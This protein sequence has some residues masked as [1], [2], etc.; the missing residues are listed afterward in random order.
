MEIS[1]L[2]DH[3]LGDYFFLFQLV[4][5]ILWILTFSFFPRLG[6]SK[7]ISLFYRITPFIF[8]PATLVFAEIRE[9]LYFQRVLESRNNDLVY[10]NLTLWRF[11]GI[12]S[13]GLSG[14][15]LGL[16]AFRRNTGANKPA[17]DKPDPAAS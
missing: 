4:W 16:F 8:L 10:D 2:T 14:L 3:L 1:L 13:Y 9:Y 12:V 15:I 7:T 5:A 11:T 6:S 17:M